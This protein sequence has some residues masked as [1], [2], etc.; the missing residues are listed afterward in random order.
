TTNRQHRCRQEAEVRYLLVLRRWAQAQQ[1]VRAEQ[2]GARRDEMALLGGGVYISAPRRTRRLFQNSHRSDTFH[3][4]HFPQSFHLGFLTLFTICFP[5]ISS[6]PSIVKMASYTSVIREES[7]IL[8]SGFLW[9][10]PPT[11]PSPAPNRPTTPGSSQEHPVWIEK[12]ER[13]RGGLGTG[14]SPNDESQQNG[15]AKSTQAARSWARPLSSGTSGSSQEDPIDVDAGF[16]RNY[17]VPLASNTRPQLKIL[18]NGAVGPAP[19]GLG[20]ATPSNGHGSSQVSG[21]PVTSQWRQAMLEDGRTDSSAADPPV[22]VPGSGE[23]FTCES[24]TVESSSTRY[25]QFRSEETSDSA[26]TGGDAVTSSEQAC[27]PGNGASHRSSTTFDEWEE[28][29]GKVRV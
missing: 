17:F 25:Q 22:P 6:C 10:I 2:V 11:P 20:E 7:P 27:G 13:H 4:R 18:T 12:D 16:T 23:S 8:P 21:S 5:P 24:P 14:A 28:A 3:N 26:T 9:H 1:A 19:A 29:E 15:N